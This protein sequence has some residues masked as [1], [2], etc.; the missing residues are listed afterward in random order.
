MNVPW[1]DDTRLRNIPAEMNTNSDATSLRLSNYTANKTTLS[2]V[3]E[4]LLKTMLK[5][6]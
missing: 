5:E 1:T 4:K 3:C 6:P 2:Y